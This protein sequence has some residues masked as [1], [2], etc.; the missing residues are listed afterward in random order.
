MRLEIRIQMEKDDEKTKQD[1]Q[2]L[3][4][5]LK[6]NGVSMIR[7]ERRMGE[8]IYRIKGDE[9]TIRKKMSRG[10]GAKP[11]TANLKIQDIINIEEKLKGKPAEKEEALAK[12][13]LKIRRYQQ[14]KKDI[15]DRYGSLEQAVAN[16]HIYF[17]SPKKRNN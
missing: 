8:E 3:K 2:Y 6:R 15:C 14:I 12:V 1:I 13:G 4:N 7:I 16:G 5:I 10:A 17:V 9:D 11:K